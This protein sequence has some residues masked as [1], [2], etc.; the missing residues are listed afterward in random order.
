MGDDGGDSAE[1]LDVKAKR[2]KAE[3]LVCRQPTPKER[4]REEKE[5]GHRVNQGQ[6]LVLSR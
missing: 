6:E 4:E 5:G 1:S 2:E 3:K